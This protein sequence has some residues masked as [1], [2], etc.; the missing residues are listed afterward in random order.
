[1]LAEYRRVLPYLAPHRWTL[2]AIVFASLVSTATGLALPLINQRLID[3]GL[4]ARRLDVLWQSVAVMA[5]VTVLGFAL[6]IASSYA[7]VRVSAAAL[8]A[9]RLDVYRHLQTLSPRRHAQ[10]Q[11]GDFVSRLNNDVAEVQRVTADTILSLLS[12]FVFLVG[13]AALMLKLSGALTLVSVAVLPVTLWLVRRMQQRMAAHVKTM[14]ERSAGIGSFL[15]ESLTG[16]KLTVLSNAQ[17]RESGRFRAENSRFVEAL[18]KMQFTGFVAGAIPATAVTLSTAAVFLVG[19]QQVLDGRL[20][21]GA[22]V[23]FLAFH[24]R[25]L[26][27]VQNLMS[28]YGNLVTGAVSLRRVREVLDI[29]PGV[30]E[31]ATPRALVSGALEFDSVSFYDTLRDVSLRVEPGEW[32]ALTGASGAGKST[33]A[34]LAA[35]LA[36]PSSGRVTLGGIDLGEL[37]LD[38]VRDAV[39]VLEQPPIV[40][41][42]TVADNIS[43][44]RPDASTEELAAAARRA[45]LDLPLDRPTGDRGTALSAGERQRIAI[46]RLLLR[47]PLVAVLDE[48]TTALD[49]DARDIVMRSLREA[50]PTALLITHDAALAATADRIVRLDAA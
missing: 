22:L 34:E 8:F 46:A 38:R 16:L 37:P 42:G 15:I 2:A 7:Y 20:T 4:L 5:A 27:P 33:V 41:G 21:L 11:M 29:P 50:F 25:L 26:A 32:V 1:M 10:T 14:R 30:V 43:Y 49:A 12:N 39:A 17:G 13:A 40:F 44:A 18:L 35:R 48:P 3:Q 6:N 23:A 47:R 24:A 19:G 9:M 28:I 31:S 36:D 45:A